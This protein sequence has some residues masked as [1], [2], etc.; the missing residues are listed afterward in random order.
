M[1]GSF[2]V[3]LLATLVGVLV[4]VIAAILVVERYSESVRVA[5]EREAAL[6]KRRYEAMWEGYLH[7]GV[8]IVSAQVTHL[9]LFVAF[10]RNRYLELL[11]AQGDTSEVPDKVARF[12]PWLAVSMYEGENEKRAGSSTTS[13]ATKG[14]N[15]RDADRLVRAFQEEATFNCACN[16][17]DLALLVGYIGFVRGRLNDEISLFQPFLATRMGLGRA[18]V[19]LSRSMSDCIQALETC[20]L[21]SPE[22]SR[23]ADGGAA[24][25]RT[26]CHQFSE[27][28]LRAVT[29]AKFM[30]SGK[31]D[32][33]Q[34]PDRGAGEPLG[35]AGRA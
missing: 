10:G 16:Q 35:S 17:A 32:L 19:K 5:V 33:S 25:E 6:E 3:G 26:V 12:L 29:V 24:R 21:A 28:G 8:S 30:M 7:G 27:L 1:L 11:E 13:L 9:C 15:E 20:C 34:L 14:M 31:D 4:A 23:G 2:L 22:E 18:L